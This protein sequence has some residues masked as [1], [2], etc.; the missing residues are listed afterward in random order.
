MRT[1]LIPFLIHI[2]HGHHEI[3][4]IFGSQCMVKRGMRVGGKGWSAIDIKMMTTMM[5]R[6][7][8]IGE[9]CKRVGQC[10][11]YISICG[12]GGGG[13]G[14]SGGVRVIVVVIGEQTSCA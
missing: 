14:G 8:G 4:M 12:A 5:I 6:V 2:H 10:R 3:T 1:T 7:V 9:G 13:G 11:R